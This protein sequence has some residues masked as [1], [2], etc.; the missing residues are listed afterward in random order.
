MGNGTILR[1]HLSC[2]NVKIKCVYLCDL[3]HNLEMMDVG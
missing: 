2:T 3:T 1:I